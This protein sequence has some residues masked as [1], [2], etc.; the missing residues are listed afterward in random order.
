MFLKNLNDYIRRFAFR[1]VS[2]SA[3]SLILVALA[4]ADFLVLA[5]G[6]TE[7]FL[8]VAFN[9][10][11]DSTT[12]TCKT[13]EF[14]NAT[15]Q[16]IANYL[17]IVFTVLRVI[18]VYLLHKVSIYCTK[19]RA[20]IAVAVTLGCSI[21]FHLDKVNRV[22]ALDIIDGQNGTDCRF[23]GKRAIFYDTYF[24]W[25]NLFLRALVPFLILIIC[26]CMIICKI[27]KL[28]RE[29]RD[30]TTSSS[31]LKS[32]DSNS[33][34]AMLVSISALFLLTQTP[35]VVTTIIEKGLDHESVSQEYIQRFYIVEAVFRILQFV[36]NVANFFCY[37]ISG[38]KFRQE[39]LSIV[40]CDVRGKGM[41]T[42]VNDHG[43]SVSSRVTLNTSV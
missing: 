15:V 24:T 33:M 26:N 5:V 3:S 17:I 6:I 1:P 25:F 12:F 21:A 41:R 39:L 22:V 30:L 32:D 14:V 36:N 40:R 38:R 34:S 11:I 28:R 13:Y 18:A 4:V 42:E 7:H 29:R 31:R 9:V 2:R 16:Y 10:R 23:Q 35:L 8:D 20:Y 43:P 37:C 27:V 19:K